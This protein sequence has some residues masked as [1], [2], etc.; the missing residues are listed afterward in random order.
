M[1]RMFLRHYGAIFHAMNIAFHVKHYIFVAFKNLFTLMKFTEEQAREALRAELTN[2]GRK[3]LAMSDR[4][5]AKQ[6]EIL[7]KR[8][9]DEEMGLPDFVEIAIEILNPMND[10]IR[11]DKSDFANKWKEDHPE[12][13]PP[14]EPQPPTEP[15]PKESPEL[16]ALMER[17]AALEKDKAE[18]DKR[19]SIAQKRSD[20]VAKLKEKGVKDDEWLNDFLSEVN[21]GDDFDVDAKTDTYVKLYNKSVASGGGAVPP[22]NPGGTTDDDIMKS[23]KAASE[24]A[25]KERSVIETKNE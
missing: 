9:A 17:I 7:V 5:L 16:K 20:L 22:G 6:T 2:K 10:N 13:E 14:A 24:L 25:K 18:S 8:L 21:I 4:T 1:R 11:K 12:P 3:S 15:T 19:A 23:I